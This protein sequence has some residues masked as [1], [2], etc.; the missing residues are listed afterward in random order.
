MARPMPA[1]PWPTFS[2]S[3]T[4][5]RR[6]GMARSTNAERY[7]RLALEKSPGCRLRP[8]RRRSAP[9]VQEGPGPG[10]AAEADT[11]LKLSP[12]YA[13]AHNVRGIVATPTGASQASRRSPTS[14]APC[15]SIPLFSQQYIHFL[16]SAYLVAG[17]FEAA[18]ALFKERIRLTPKTDLSRAFLAVCARPSGRDRPTP[19]RLARADGDQSEIL[20]HRACRTLA[21]PT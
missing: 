3:R 12:N 14:S 2:N 6:I 5:G 19:A 4:T 10:W 17:R 15:G 11:A 16:G 9:H 20:V 13:L 7:V 8:L 18:A 1:P 21:L